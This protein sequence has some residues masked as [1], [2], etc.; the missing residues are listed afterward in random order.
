MFKQE[1]SERFKLFFNEYWSLTKKYIINHDQLTETEWEIF[2]LDIELIRNQYKNDVFS[3]YMKKLLCSLIE[4]MEE[5][6]HE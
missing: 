3:F 5:K 1:Q 2:L 4:S 6:K